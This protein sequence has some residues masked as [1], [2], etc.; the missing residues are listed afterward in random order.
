[1]PEGPEVRRITEKLRS[2][3]KGE[4]L[5][6]I[7][8][9]QNT[10][11]SSNLNQIVPQIESRF[12]LT[13]LDILCRGKQIF[14]F[15]SDGIA[16]IS[17]LGMEGHWYYFKS[18]PN[19]YPSVYKY[20]TGTNYGKF[21]LYFGKAPKIDDTSINLSIHITE[22]ELWYDDML[23]YGNFTITSWSEAFNK[24]KE[25]GPDLLA[26][27]N[28]ISNINSTVQPLLPI[29]FTQ[30]ATLDI[31]KQSIRSSRRAKMELC[32]FLMKQEYFS[33]IGN[34]LRSEILYRSRLHPFRFLSSLSD[35]EISLLFSVC[36]TTISHAYSCGGL[37]HGTFL[38]PDQ[39]KGT[40]PVFVYKR[41]GEYDP[42]GFIIKRIQDSDKRSIFFVEEIQK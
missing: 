18:G 8:W 31:F 39:E 6:S 21:C 35:N 33:A 26:T 29:E 5:I 10:K 38:D 30:F 7:V 41:E 28:P 11:Y 14:F 20:L 36:L 25:I 34:Y 24:M 1:M 9:H 23:S 17:G 37:T 19:Q 40:F 32:R 27:T 15:F 12:P 42:N 3:L 13:C 22:V 16:F 2:R 4:Q